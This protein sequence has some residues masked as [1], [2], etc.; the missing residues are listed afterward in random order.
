[1]KPRTYTLPG[2]ISAALTDAGVELCALD[3][4][5]VSRLTTLE[6]LLEALDEMSEDGTAL[7][8]WLRTEMKAARDTA[9]WARY[10]ALKKALAVLE[11]GEP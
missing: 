9:R 4:V 11:G 10:D 6:E 5:V 2:G 3:G 1:M 7:A 8:E